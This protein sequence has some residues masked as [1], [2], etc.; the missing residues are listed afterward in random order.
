[1]MEQEQIHGLTLRHCAEIIAKDGALRAEH[2]ERGYKP[3]LHQFLATKGVDEN[4]FAHAWNAWHARMESDPSG[5]LY[6]KYSTMQ[7]EFMQQVAFADVPDMTQDAKGGVTLDAY[8][9]ISAGIAGG[10]DY[11]ALLQKHGLDHAR[12]QQAQSAWTAAMAADVNHHITTQ[13]GQLYAKYTPGF[14][15][16]ME[17]STA[18][19]MA[20][21]YAERTMGLDDE[22]EREYTFDDML[23]EMQSNA[24][25]TRWKAAHH[26][27]NRWDIAGSMERAAPTLAQ[28]IKRAYELAHE[29]I[30][31][32][33]EFTVSDAEALSEDLQMLASEGYMSAAMSS[34]SQ[35]AI[36][37]CLSRGQDHLGTLRAGFAPIADKAVPERYK[38]Q[39]AI[40]DYESLTETLAEILEEWE[41]NYRAPEA[42]QPAQGQQPFG[43]QPSPSM[44]H[45]Q[46][47]AHAT[48]AQSNGLLDILRKLPLIGN[49][50]RLLGL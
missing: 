8:A 36:G 28:P 1:M 39:S 20:A 42:A 38:M 47:L 34:D 19:I 30:E 24:R 27:M 14:Q 25:P 4:T 33:D 50:I 6:A 3:Y 16:N 11:T 13:Y 18:S 29:C 48:P 12:W 26:I 45:S 17:A 21:N 46:S 7:G 49:L 9:E 37:R 23:G 2:G 35:G 31:S 15:Q 10:K 22:P 32:H 44:A 40:Q 43:Q 5:Q 41:D